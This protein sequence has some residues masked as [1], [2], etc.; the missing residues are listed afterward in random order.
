[1]ANETF[2]KLLQEKFGYTADLKTVVKDGYPVSS[3]K[4]EP[5]KSAHPMEKFRNVIKVILGATD[6]EQDTELERAIDFD[7]LFRLATKHGLAPM[8]LTNLE[9]IKTEINKPKSKRDKEV[10]STAWEGVKDNIPYWFLGV[11]PSKDDEKQED[12]ELVTQLLDVMS[13]FNKERNIY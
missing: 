7:A 9:T 10:I 11:L 6:T 13:Y 3:D 2:R 4:K 1:M 5:Q 8:V 12:K